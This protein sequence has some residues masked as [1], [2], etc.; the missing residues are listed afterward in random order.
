[1]A[2]KKSITKAEEAAA[3]T[4]TGASK[5]T[6]CRVVA[7]ELETSVVQAKL[8]VNAVLN[9]IVTVVL[10]QGDSDKPKLSISDFG[11]FNVKKVASKAGRNPMTGEAITCAPTVRITFKPSSAVKDKVITAVWAGK[12]R[13]VA[14]PAKAA[15]TAIKPRAQAP[16]KKN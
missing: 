4:M 12:S 13:A 9:S 16:A 6:L 8:M 1:M 15:V 11:T 14:I 7:G 5:D 2:N 3:P 10:A